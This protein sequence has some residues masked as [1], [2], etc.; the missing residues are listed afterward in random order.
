MKIP[1][2]IVSRL[3][4]CVNPSLGSA[5]QPKSELFYGGDKR[6]KKHDFI[7]FLKSWVG[8][9]DIIQPL[10]KGAFIRLV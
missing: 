6:F 8:L 7:T 2:Y 9:V 5:N 4:L 1:K 10:T 3:C